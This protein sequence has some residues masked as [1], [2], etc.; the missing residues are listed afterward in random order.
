MVKYVKL[1]KSRKRIKDGDVFIIKVDTGDY[2]LGRV[3]SSNITSDSEKLNGNHLIVFYKKTEQYIEEIDLSE[4]IEGSKSESFFIVPNGFW[5]KGIFQNIGNIPLSK[6][7]KDSIGTYIF[8][9]TNYKHEVINI[10]IYNQV[11]QDKILSQDKTGSLGGPS[12]GYILA[13]LKKDI[14]FAENRLK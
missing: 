3:L 11:I 9:Y 14:T 2:I 4:K 5:T 10:N 8:S 13:C 12:I 7:E 6:K 1:E